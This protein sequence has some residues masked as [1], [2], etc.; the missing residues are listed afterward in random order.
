MIY[1]GGE[2]ELAGRY[3][4]RPNGKWWVVN[5]IYRGANLVW[6]AIRSCFGAGFWVN[7]KPWLNTEGWKNE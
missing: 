5:E 6:A 3:R 4:F 1:K 7:E 2:N